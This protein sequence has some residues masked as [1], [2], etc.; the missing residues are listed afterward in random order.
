MFRQ[1][2]EGKLYEEG[3]HHILDQAEQE[4]SGEETLINLTP[5]IPALLYSNQ[6]SQTRII[7]F[8]SSPGFS[9]LKPNL[10]SAF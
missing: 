3:K 6:V 1:Y 10:S 4:I 7:V 9:L 2:E 8:K 5:L